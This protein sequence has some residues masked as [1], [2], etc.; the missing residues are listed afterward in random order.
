MF[1]SQYIIYVRELFFQCWFGFSV[2]EVIQ[3]REKLIALIQNTF[4]KANK[5]LKRVDENGLLMNEGSI[6]VDLQLANDDRSVYDRYRCRFE[7]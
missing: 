4:D 3:N 6:F 2:P 1:V 7:L 5:V